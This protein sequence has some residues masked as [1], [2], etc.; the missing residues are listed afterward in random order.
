MQ[1]VTKVEQQIT[2][3]KRATPPFLFARFIEKSTD[4]KVKGQYLDVLLA[5]YFRLGIPPDTYTIVGAM[6]KDGNEQKLVIT[7]TVEARTMLAE[8]NK[9]FGS[10]KHGAVEFEE[11]GKTPRCATAYVYRKDCDEPFE[12]TVY[13]R[14]YVATAYATQKPTHIWATKGAQ[15]TMK[16]AIGAALKLAY[17]NATSG[18]SLPE[19]VARPQVEA[20]ETHAA[21]FTGRRRVD[22]ETGEVSH[23]PS[24]ANPAVTAPPAKTAQPEPVAAKAETPK[25]A[26]P[27]AATASET[28]PVSNPPKTDERLAHG[29]FSPEEAAIGKRAFAGLS[30]ETQKALLVS[31]IYSEFG[32]DARTIPVAQHARVMAIVCH[33]L[34]RRPPV[35]YWTDLEV[36]EMQQFLEKRQPAAQPAP[37]LKSADEKPKTEERS[38]TKKKKYERDPNRISYIQISS[39]EHHI[40]YDGASLATIQNLVRRATNGRTD[41][42][43]KL[44]KDEATP[45]LNA[46]SAW[47]NDLWA[48]GKH[49]QQKGQ[50]QPVA[51]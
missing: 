27:L 1:Q 12:A 44:T 10:I 30:A 3:W 35:I 43:T 42:Y 51:A 17:P 49:K 15:M 19:E 28:A 31:Q 4:G 9:N 8:R 47:A 34:N 11:D 24:T 20:S 2:D 7:I 37:E 41:D 39:F 6:R 32:L 21:G 36:G 22:M 25:E 5:E 23:V 46:I 50:Q 38:A 29:Q 14:E 45:V 26:A 18:L 33:E 16:C 48:K 40:E 13:Y